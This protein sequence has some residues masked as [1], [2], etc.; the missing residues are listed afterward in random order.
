MGTL[1]KYAGKEKLPENWLY[2]PVKKGNTKN[3]NDFFNGKTD[4]FLNGKLEI[5][6][7]YNGKKRNKANP[8]KPLELGFLYV[9]NAIGTSLYK[10]GISHEFNR[11]FKDISA[12]SPL[13]LSVCICAKMGKPQ[14]AEKYLHEKYNHLYFKNDWFNLQ[15]N[16]FED[17]R[18]FIE[19][20]YG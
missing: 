11:R 13:P 7:I 1:K 14:I 12:N 4:V 6:P 18:L 10:I 3:D 15:H 17:I 8:Q 5:N 9:L 16:D 2:R 19:Q 20:Y